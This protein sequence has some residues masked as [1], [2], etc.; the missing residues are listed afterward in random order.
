M[1][2]NEFFSFQEDEIYLNKILKENKNDDL[3]SFIDTHEISFFF[4]AKIDEKKL[5]S[6]KNIN[7]KISL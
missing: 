1:E 6:K 2:R 7:N 4:H 3:L 5:T